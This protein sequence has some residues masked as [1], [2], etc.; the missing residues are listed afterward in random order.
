MSRKYLIEKPCI[1]DD[2]IRQ[3]KDPRTLYGP[4]RKDA[5]FIFLFLGPRGVSHDNTSNYIISTPLFSL[6]KSCKFLMDLLY[7]HQNGMKRCHEN[8]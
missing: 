4:Y 6:F 7:M 1:F 5:L 8:K 3:I 2:L